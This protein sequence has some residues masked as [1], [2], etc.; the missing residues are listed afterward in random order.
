MSEAARLITEVLG[1]G[2]LALEVGLAAFLGWWF[3]HRRRDD[4]QLL[5]LIRTYSLPLI[6]ILGLVGSVLTLVYSEVFG[7]APCGLC[8]LQRVFLYPI[9]LLS[10]LGLL[11]KDRGIFDYVIGLSVPGFVLA[12]YQHYLQLGG[13]SFLPCPAAPGAADCAQRLIFEFGHITFPYMA[14]VLFATLVV[15]SVMGKRQEVPRSI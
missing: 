4:L 7:F 3:I 13:G 5:P 6:F 14:A 10:A 9:V 1:I 12:L 2:V 11:K 8:W 15:L